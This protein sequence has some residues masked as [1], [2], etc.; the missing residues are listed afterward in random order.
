MGIYQPYT[1][2]I[3]HISTGLKYYGVRYARNCSP[4]DLWV[5]YFSSSRI[6]QN[7]IR[8][9]GASS[10][11]AEIRKTFSTKKEAL[12]WE[13][14]VLRR[15]K[16]I[17]NPNWLNQSI[18]S[19]KFYNKGGYK[20]SEATINKKKGENHYSCRLKKENK[21]N[22]LIGL[23]RSETTKIA[24]SISK[25]GSNNPRST[26]CELYDNHGQLIKM[27]CTKKEL[28]IYLKEHD[29]PSTLVNYGTTYD[30][31]L[32][33]TQNIRYKKFV[34]YITKKI[35]PEEGRGDPLPLFV[36]A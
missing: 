15:L 2:C 36:S 26:S 32:W 24:L 13:E 9:D 33:N 6:V 10:F 3:T 29:M 8:K 23:K 19:K 14:K 30:P 34:G 7:I 31:Y 25:L 18:S 1:Y 5:K 12:L 16:V 4:N 20:L 17:E 27:F 22:P 28:I 11:A 35:T 21:P